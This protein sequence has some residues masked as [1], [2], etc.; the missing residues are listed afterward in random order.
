MPATWRCLRHR[1]RT[2][3]LPTEER[4]DISK[5]TLGANDSMNRAMLFS[6]REVVAK[7]LSPEMQIDHAK[8]HA[9]NQVKQ[10]SFYTASRL[11]YRLGE[12]KC[13]LAAIEIPRSGA[14]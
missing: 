4:C 11:T 12:S 8:H 1:R 5:C 6:V 2:F 13:D 7:G 14:Y 10:A 9:A 3:F